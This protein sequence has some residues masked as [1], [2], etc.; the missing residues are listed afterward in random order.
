MYDLEADCTETKDLADTYPKKADELAA[1]WD[2]WAKRV[3]TR[4]SGRELNI[5]GV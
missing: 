3:N 4:H 5:K 2:A 1:M